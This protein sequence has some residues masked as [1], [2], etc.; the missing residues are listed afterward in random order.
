MTRMYIRLDNSAACQHRPHVCV[1]ACT[2]PP[3][4]QVHA[5]DANTKHSSHEQNTNRPKYGWQATEH[6]S[7]ERRPT[8]HT[9]HATP[10]TAVDA[11]NKQNQPHHTATLN[12]TTTN[13]TSKIRKK[14][15]LQTQAQ[16]PE[17]PVTHSPMSERMRL[18]RSEETFRTKHLTPM[19][20][21]NTLR[22]FLV[23]FASLLRKASGTNPRTDVDKDTSTPS[24][25]TSVMTPLSHQVTSHHIIHDGARQA[26]MFQSFD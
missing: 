10:W 9:K 24:S 2:Q 22:K 6:Q 8:P 21:R 16:T 15:T 25:T 18:R 23:T 7:T 5:A 11:N 17:I 12:R 26:V 19:P 3:T 14:K 4:P 1:Y 20:L 13:N